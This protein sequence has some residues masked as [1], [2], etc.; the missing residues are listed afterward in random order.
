MG[1]DRVALIGPPPGRPATRHLW[2]DK[3]GTGLSAAP[4]PIDP[5]ASSA[6][7]SASAIAGVFTRTPVAAASRIRFG[8]ISKAMLLY[9]QE[10]IQ[11]VRIPGAL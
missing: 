4:H 3:P 10:M 1:P 2:A 5:D 9:D 8:L 6:F 11:V 7:F